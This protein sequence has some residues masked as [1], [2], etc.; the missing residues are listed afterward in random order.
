MGGSVTAAVMVLS[1]VGING[2]DRHVFEQLGCG[3]LR[4]KRKL[5]IIVVDGKSRSLFQD[6]LYFLFLFFGGCVCVCL[7]RSASLTAQK[8]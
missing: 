3:E 7:H 5:T 4:K 6:F 1:A 2:C 8:Q